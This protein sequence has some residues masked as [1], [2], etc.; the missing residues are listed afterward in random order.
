VLQSLVEP[1]ELLTSY[2]Q[3]FAA[4]Y[5]CLLDARADG[6]HALGALYKDASLLTVGARRH[7]GATAAAAAL[8]QHSAQ[9]V[10]AAV[11]G[12]GG[13]GDAALWHHHK[14]QRVD[15]QPH[16]EGGMVVYIEGH[17]DIMNAQVC[18][19]PHGL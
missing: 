2:A 16:G 4:N 18:P 15:A 8:A 5:Y 1:D 13:G 6:L 12:G 9:L 11:G 7:Q 3:L 19:A 17:I 14:V 10:A